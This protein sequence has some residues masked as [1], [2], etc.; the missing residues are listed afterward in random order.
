MRNICLY[1]FKFYNLQIMWGVGDCK[2]YK[3]GEL[4]KN[5]NSAVIHKVCD[6]NA[7]LKNLNE[8]NLAVAT[9]A[10]FN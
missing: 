8:S 3:T 10:D 2:C 6:C 9:I 4:Y 7:K 5:H 1:E